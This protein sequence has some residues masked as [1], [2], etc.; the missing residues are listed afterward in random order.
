MFKQD[1]S[2]IDIFHF[3]FFNKKVESFFTHVNAYSRADVACVFS[4]F[5]DNIEGSSHLYVIAHRP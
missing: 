3:F 2:P 5:L 1:L 4:F